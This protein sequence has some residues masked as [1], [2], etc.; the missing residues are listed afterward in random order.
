IIREHFTTLQKPGLTEREKEIACLAADGFTN[1]EIGKR[2]F[3]SENT[4][5]TQLKNIFG[6]LEINSRSLLKQYLEHD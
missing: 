1:K 6:K 4:V 2:L 3:I 5:K